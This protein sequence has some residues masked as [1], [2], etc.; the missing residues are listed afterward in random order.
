MT[1]TAL[2]LP[3][4]DSQSSDGDTGLSPQSDHS[5]WARLGQGSLE[6]GP[7]P[8]WEPEVASWRRLRHFS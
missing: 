3:S 8:A 6:E 1:E 7:G 5:E 4:Q 2:V